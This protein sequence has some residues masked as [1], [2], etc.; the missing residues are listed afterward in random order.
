MHY[1]ITHADFKQLNPDIPI[2]KSRGDKAAP[3]EEFES[4]N[5]CAPSMILQFQ[6]CVVLATK[7][8]LVKSLIMQA[9]RIEILIRA[10]PV[11][12]SEQQQV[13][14]PLWIF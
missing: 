14:P 2:T 4:E 7:E 12:I 10:L 11:P 9:K 5:S 13:L 8:D 6:H 3:P 1:L